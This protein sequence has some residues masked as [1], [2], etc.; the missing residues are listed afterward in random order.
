MDTTN[1]PASVE[2]RAVFDDYP[3]DSSGL[4]G[5]VGKV[6]L[7]L[8]NYTQSCENQLPSVW[9]GPSRVRCV[10]ESVYMERP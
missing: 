5:V 2:L 8:S 9:S 3:N 6:S 1:V 4:S 10:A 7:T